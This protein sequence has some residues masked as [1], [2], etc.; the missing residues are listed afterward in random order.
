MKLVRISPSPPDFKGLLKNSSP[1]FIGGIC[2]I[3]DF[4]GDALKNVRRSP[5]H[6]K[7]MP[8]TYC[9]RYACVPDDNRL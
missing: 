8:I 6:F 7:F 5:V 1:F 9:P 3:G 4:I 2:A